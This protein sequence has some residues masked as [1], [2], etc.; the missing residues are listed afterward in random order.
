MA[1]NQ[2]A[3]AELCRRLDALPLEIELA[4][5]WTRALSPEQIRARLGQRSNRLTGGSRAALPRQQTPQTTIEWTFDLLSPA[6]R[7]LLT[8][9]CVFA[10]RCTLD[11]IT[12]VCGSG[13]LPPVVVLDHLTSLLDKCP[14]IREDLAGA[15]RYRLHETMREYA[16]LMLREAGDEILVEQ[17]CRDYHLTRCREFVVE[18]RHCLRSGFYGWS[19]GSTPSAVCCAELWTRT[20]YRPASRSPP[21]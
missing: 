7:G 18:G 16:G 2:A 19:S 5:V 17:H 1:T 4:A 10:G 8:R 15:A 13:D 11:A 3:V 12:T 6:E 21:T 20:T 9:L 14:V